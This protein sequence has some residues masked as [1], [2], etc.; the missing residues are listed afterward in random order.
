MKIKELLLPFMVFMTLTLPGLAQKRPNVSAGELKD[1]VGFLASDDMRGRAN[2]SPEMKRA[3]EWI[4]GKLSE[5]GLKPFYSDG[6]F[7]KNYTYYAR[8]RIIAERNVIGII[9]GTDP[10]LKNQFII[11]SSHFDHVGVRKTNDPDSI[12]NGADDN[13]AGTCTVIGIARAFR[14]AGFKPGRTIIFASFSGEEN[15][16]RGSRAFVSEK[17]LPFPAVYANLNFEMTGHSEFLGKGNYYMTGCKMSGLDD[18]VKEFNKSG[19]F[20]LIDTVAMAENLFFASDNIAFSRLSVIADTVIGIPSGTF[21]TTAF[22][23]YIHSP[24]DEA[25]FFDFENMASLVNHFSELTLWMSNRKEDI[26][27]TNPKFRR[28]K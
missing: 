18:A 28:P 11:L 20:R 9:E 25:R 24:S 1:W 16:M 22:A 19:R 26:V 10:L 5:Y 15:G 12:Y 3:A 21:A 8:Q 27:W 2:G 14:E 13:A 17:A 23:D 4:A 7:I 6:S